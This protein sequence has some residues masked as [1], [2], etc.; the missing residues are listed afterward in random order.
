MGTVKRLYVLVNKRLNSVYGC[1]QGGHA[2][3]QWLLEHPQQKWNNQYLIYL[4][5]DIEHWGEK[6]DSLSIKYSAFHEPDMNGTV[7]AIAVEDDSGL[8][9]QSLKLVE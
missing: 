2:V 6:L 4:W 5:A 3:A 1:V 7:T 9:F 8:M